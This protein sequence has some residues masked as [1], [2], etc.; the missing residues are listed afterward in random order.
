[1]I[2]TDAWTVPPLFQLLARLGQVSRTE[3]Y[4]T[5]N[6]G[7]GMAVVV[8]RGREGEALDVA[9]AAGAEAT[10]VGWISEEPG[11]TLR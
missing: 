1:M 6:M 3:M 11:V 2:K 5:L 4:R 7:I 8:P 9:G 10:V